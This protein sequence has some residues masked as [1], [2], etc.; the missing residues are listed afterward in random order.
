MN[1][2]ELITKLQA[3]LPEAGETRVLVSEGHIAYKVTDAKLLDTDGK[4]FVVLLAT[5]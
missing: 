2:R 3:A 5:K 4:T 1:V